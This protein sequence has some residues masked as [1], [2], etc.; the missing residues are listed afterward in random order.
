MIK[1]ILLIICLITS[2]LC[3]SQS[4]NPNQ[5]YIKT[6]YGNVYYKIVGTKSNKPPI[7]VIH[8]GP[9]GGSCGL[10]ILELLA[11]DRQVIFYDQLGSG[12]SPVQNDDTLWQIDRY[13][14]ELQQIIQILNIE[15]PIIFAH[16]WGAAIAAK[17]LISHTNDVTAVIFASPYI[18]S[19]LWI[20][21]ANYLMSKLPPNSTLN[22]FQKS[23][24]Q[25]YPSNPP[26]DK[27]M[28]TGSVWNDH[29][30]KTMWGTSEFEVN[31]NLKSLSLY[32]DL[33][34]INI[35]SLVL[36]GQYDQVTI[37][38][39]AQYARKLPQ[40]NLIVIP[41]AAHMSMSDQPVMFIYYVKYF[42]NGC[43]KS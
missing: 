41:N 36:I 20:D 24:L 22:D 9:G 11:T 10:D 42:I 4:S 18:D 12:K 23:H 13:V 33:D 30:Y 3:Y 28:C 43:C 38:T 17:Y 15:R 27:D 7:L 32:N 39:A 34:K 1:A 2:S 25:R 40:G 29:I 6:T 16:S 26:Y 8:G 5:Q 35:P 37:S 31:G 21:D 19:Q 14:N